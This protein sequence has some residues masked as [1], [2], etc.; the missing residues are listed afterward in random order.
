MSYPAID[1]ISHDRTKA[2]ATRAIVRLG[3]SQ[4]QASTWTEL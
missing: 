4:I 1:V 2:N 3:F